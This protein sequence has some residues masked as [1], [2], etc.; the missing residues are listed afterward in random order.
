MPERDTVRKVS[1]SVS[2]GDISGMS[3]VFTDLAD[4]NHYG[5]LRLTS[6]AKAEGV[7]DYSL[8]SPIVFDRLGIT[9]ALTEV[10]DIDG[11]RWPD[12]Q[13][14]LSGISYPH[15]VIKRAA[16]SARNLTHLQNIQHDA[17]ALAAAMTEHDIKTRN[18][19]V[20]N[21]GETQKYTANRL[22]ELDGDILKS[23]VE[24]FFGVV[25]SSRMMRRWTPQQWNRR[26]PERQQELLELFR[27]TLSGEAS[28]TIDLPESEGVGNGN[29][30]M[31]VQ[32][33]LD[34]LMTSEREEL[35]YRARELLFDR[36]RIEKDLAWNPD[37]HMGL[38]PDEAYFRDIDIPP[39]TSRDKD[40]T[41]VL[42]RHLGPRNKKDIYDRRRVEFWTER[43]TR[44][45]RPILRWRRDDSSDE[46][47]R[48][49]R[50]GGGESHV[51]HDGSEVKLSYHSPL[52]GATIAAIHFGN[53]N[54][55]NDV[56]KKYF[57]VNQLSRRHAGLL[58]L[59]LRYDQQHVLDNSYIRQAERLIDQHAD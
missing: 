13:K 46:P 56:L 39:G 35:E 4:R 37:D 44:I 3:T 9:N 48:T 34:C 40:T 5:K 12:V 21:Y 49:F 45:V 22:Y 43:P 1:M 30:S 51:T 15:R 16:R 19:P 7:T 24:Q 32:E 53:Q 54:D 8:E 14:G 58:P 38:P 31:S 41:V 47:E 50:F 23:I 17:G 25:I 55:Y 11:V 59:V 33:L 28:T 10:L 26:S 42:G 36:F 29:D 20:F 52:M 6:H 57:T 18:I 27:A 2:E